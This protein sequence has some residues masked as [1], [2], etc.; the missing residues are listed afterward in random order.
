MYVSG[1]KHAEIEDDGIQAILD[2][3]G[4]S[5]SN[6]HRIYLWGNQVSWHTRVSCHIFF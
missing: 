5:E 1:L 3:V 2:A 4:H 6:L